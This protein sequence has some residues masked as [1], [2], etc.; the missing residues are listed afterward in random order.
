MTAPTHVRVL[1]IDPNGRLL[2]AKREDP[3]SRTCIWEP[4][5]GAIEHGE[6]P[7][8]AAIREIREETGIELIEPLELGESVHRSYRWKGENR[9]RDELIFRVMLAQSPAVSSQM[10]DEE[11]S[12]FVDWR[13]VEQ[14]ELRSLDAPWYPDDPFAIALSRRST[15]ARTASD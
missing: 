8:I 14:R 9:E 15:S 7:E 13:W 6:T 10:G 11:R 4:P 2:L 5:G 1:L 12:T 3:H